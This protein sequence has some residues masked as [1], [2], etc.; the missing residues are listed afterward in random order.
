MKHKFT[1]KT[2]EAIYDR[3][4]W[5]CIYCHSPQ[6]LTPHHVYFSP[7]EKFYDGSQNNIDKGVSLC[8]TCH[9]ALHD[10]K[11]DQSEFCHNYLKE[12]YANI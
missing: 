4:G 10:N 11:G 6:Q 2:S 1:K 9:R 12:L 3:D 8:F 7:L 5:R